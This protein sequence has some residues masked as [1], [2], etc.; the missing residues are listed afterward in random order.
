MADPPEKFRSHVP[1]MAGS[2][3]GGL[4]T[5]VLGSHLFG[6]LGTGAG[7]VLGSCLSGTVSWWAERGIRRSQEITRA[8][9]QAARKRG[10]CL[11]VTETQ[12]IEKEAIRNFEKKNSGFHYATIGYL[13]LVAIGVCV[14]TVVILDR[15]GAREVATFRPAPQPAVTRTVISP[16]PTE[17]SVSPPPVLSPSA[18]VSQSVSATPSPDA[19]PVVPSNPTPGA[20]SGTLEPPSSEPNSPSI[21][22]TFPGTAYPAQTGN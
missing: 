4:L 17:T 8:K 11:S 3:I 19:S 14:L 2:T 6:A 15:V 21:G 18:S 9:I 1:A 5:A 16:P 10:R 7:L 20:T 22:P 13:A 12:Q